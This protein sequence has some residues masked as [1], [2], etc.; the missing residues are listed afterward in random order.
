MRVF[1][2]IKTNANIQWKLD[3]GEWGTWDTM[4][5]AI[6]ALDGSATGVATHAENTLPAAFEDEAMHTV[7]W[8]WIFSNGATGDVTDTAMGNKVDLDQVKLVITIT[9]TQID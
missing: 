6:E 2:G 5:A 4:I 3:N 7:Y 9:A 8:R 1:L